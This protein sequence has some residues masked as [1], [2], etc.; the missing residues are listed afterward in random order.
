MSV[1]AVQRMP[2]AHPTFST[3]ENDIRH[4]GDRPDCPENVGDCLY[5]LDW[6]YSSDA[7][8]VH[9]HR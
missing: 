6:C 5:T 7:L 8:T 2:T 4:S 3:I 1:D 9:A